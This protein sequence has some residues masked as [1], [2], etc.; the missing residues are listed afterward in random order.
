[1]E[2]ATKN[3]KIFTDCQKRIS[4]V[5]VFMMLVVGSNDRYDSDFGL[6]FLYFFCVGD[7]SDGLSINMFVLL[8]HETSSNRQ[9]THLVNTTS[10]NGIYSTVNF[11]ASTRFM[12][13][14]LY[15]NRRRFSECA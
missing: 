9:L 1:M 10:L 15:G 8:E 7:S 14:I 5:F 4:I 2:N 12:D 11:Y 13:D 6:L 3:G